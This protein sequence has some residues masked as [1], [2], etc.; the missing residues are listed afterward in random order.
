MSEQGEW[1][2]KCPF[3]GKGCEKP[4]VIGTAVIKNINE[5]DCGSCCKCVYL[6]QEE[7]NKHLKEE[8]NQGG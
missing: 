2:L 1:I 7:Y 5:Y 4:S 8:H 6:T 3:C